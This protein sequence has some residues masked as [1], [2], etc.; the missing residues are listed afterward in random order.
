[1]MACICQ[2]ANADAAFM[3]G[4]PGSAVAAAAAAAAIEAWA[5]AAYPPYVAAARHKSAK[6]CCSSVTD[7][8]CAARSSTISGEPS[9]PSSESEDGD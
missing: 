9:T 6:A 7:G 2:G 5:R 4:A 1:M 3:P 8:L